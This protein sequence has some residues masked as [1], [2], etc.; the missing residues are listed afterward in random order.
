[1]TLFCSHIC[2]LGGIRW[3]QLISA[4]FSIGL[5]LEPPAGARITKGLLTC[6]V[7]AGCWLA[8]QLDLWPKHLHMAFLCGCLAL[9]QHGA[10][11]PR[12]SIPRE[13]AKQK[14]IAFSN[15]ALEVTLHHF[16]Y[17]LFTRSELPRLI[18][19]QEEK[20]ETPLFD[21]WS[22]KESVDIFQNYHRPCGAYWLSMLEKGAVFQR[23]GCL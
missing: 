8:P 6:L 10:W 11:V 22:V 9:S 16:C 7:D 3:G 12:A 4:L 21:S 15:L 19:V 14:H 5:G 13:R 17:I 2:C 23:A 1:M 20:N 18:C